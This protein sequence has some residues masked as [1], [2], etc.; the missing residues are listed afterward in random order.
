MWVLRRKVRAALGSMLKALIGPAVVWIPLAPSLAAPL[1]APVVIPLH[2]VASPNDA[3][4][5]KLGIYAALNDGSQPEL[6]EF[7]TGGTG[8]LAT[9]ACDRSRSR[10]WGDGSPVAPCPSGPPPPGC[11]TPSAA[12]FCTIYD[13]GLQYNGN[14]VSSTV[15][16]FASQQGPVA[17]STPRLTLGQTLFITGGSA[18]S[19]PSGWL[20]NDPDG[21]GSFRPPVQGRFYGDFGMAI[22]PSSNGIPTLIQQDSFWTLFDPDKVKRGFRVHASDETPWVQF[23]LTEQDLQ[24]ATMRF[25]LDREYG[26]IRTGSLR[27]HKAGANQDQ[28]FSMKRNTMLIFDT[29]ATTTIHSGPVLITGQNDPDG[30]FPCALTTSVCPF[31][32][33]TTSST[34]LDGAHVRVQALSLDPGVGEL[35][36]LSFVAGDNKATERDYNQVTIQGMGTELAPACALLNNPQACYYL[37]TGILPFLHYDVITVL[38]PGPDDRLNSDSPAAAADT[39][40]IVLELERPAVPAPAPLLALAGVFGWSRRLRNRLRHRLRQRPEPASPQR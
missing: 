37:N 19:D 7:D 29:G 25:R 12:T 40:R 2:W 31:P 4:T 22:K 10:W 32:Q 8:F 27:V 26:G 20:A 33:G 34:V 13:S 23:G 1:S 16:L 39:P 38:E 35:D 30:V 15:Q 17:L 6:F 9:E 21:S 36:L 24:G 11:P 18:K 28:P 3:S 14:I 5:R